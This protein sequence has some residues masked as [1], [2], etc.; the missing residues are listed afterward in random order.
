MTKE[1]LEFKLK[2]FI[3]VYGLLSNGCSGRMFRN[4]AKNRVITP[5]FLLYHAATLTLIRSGYQELLYG[6]LE[7]LT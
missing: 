7:K 4:M 2:D 1:S 6:G 5:F 3:P